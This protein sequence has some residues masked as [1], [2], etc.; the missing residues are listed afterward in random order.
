MVTEV[1]VKPR[2]PW[3]SRFTTVSCC[4]VTAA[5][6]AAC[7]GAEEAD[8]LSV[9]F[10]ASV[11]LINGVRPDSVTTRISVSVIRRESPVPA[12]VRAGPPGNLV[13]I[14]SF[15][16]STDLPGYHQELRAEI[17]VEGRH[18]EYTLRLPSF[19]TVAL[20]PDPPEPSRELLVSWQPFAEPGVDPWVHVTTPSSGSSRSLFV[21]DPAVTRDVGQVQVPA[22]TFSGDSNSFRAAI[23]DLNV[24]RATRIEETD[25]DGTKYRGI[26]QLDFWLE[27]T[28]WPKRATP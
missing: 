8:R 15:A 25:R 23:Y 20:I 24:I 27:R 28:V 3:W 21:L 4:C 22:G 13:A 19:F 17:E 5:L 16:A 1:N 14:D 11:T 12:V 10:G 26:G 9:Q 2:T 6:S 7:V 18:L